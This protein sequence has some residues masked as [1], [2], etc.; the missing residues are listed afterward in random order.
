MRY[1][2]YTNSSKAW[3]GIFAA[4]RTA[5][6]SIYIEMYIF[7]ADTA[8][9]HDF[10]GKLTEKAKAGVSV[11]VIADA[12]GSLALK[13][14]A[15]AELKAAGGEF[16]YFSHWLKRMHR[17]L[18]IVDEE[19]AFIGGVNIENKIRNWVDLQIK[20]KGPIIRPFLR[21][22]ARTYQKC[23]GKNKEI[24]AYSRE[25]LVRK[26]K[27]WVVDNWELDD[28]EYNIK[29]YYRIK[30]EQAHEHIQIVTP[31]IMPPRWLMASLDMA[32]RRGVRVDIIY[33]EDTD[34]KSLNRL[35]HINACRL[36]EV[37]VNFYCTPQMNHAKVMIIDEHEALVGS[38]NLDLLS[39][40]PNLEI[41]VFFRQ[42]EAVSALIKIVGQWQTEAKRP[43]L[44][45]KKMSLK[46]RLLM[47]F[48]RIFFPFF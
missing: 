13:S 40:G 25:L 21:S 30:L 23:G 15:V 29:H 18:V 43:D 20:L 42:K 1:K 12:Y 27:S 4:I 47:I 28:K 33:P 8:Q 46:T 41:G 17:K 31:Y 38:Q 7:L 35:N 36:A 26:I 11:V 6:K 16:I 3:D 32:V 39:F 24:L 10:I 37:G 19:F 2:F 45:A 34:I 48:F 44:N 9:T 22:F 14:A 5:R